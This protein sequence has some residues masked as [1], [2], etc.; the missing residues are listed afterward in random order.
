MEFKILGVLYT[1]FLYI[2]FFCSKLLHRL[3]INIS[4]KVISTVSPFQYKV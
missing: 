1:P 2:F 3:V 4:M